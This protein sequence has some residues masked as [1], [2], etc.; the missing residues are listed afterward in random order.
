MVTDDQIAKTLKNARKVL[1]YSQRQIAEEIGSSRDIVADCENLRQR[2]T[3]THL[4]KTL[5]LLQQSDALRKISSL[6]DIRNNNFA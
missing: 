1:G 4:I 6:L 5:S 3:A 2:T